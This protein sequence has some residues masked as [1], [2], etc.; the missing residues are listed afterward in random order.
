MTAA[1]TLAAAWSTAALDAYLKWYHRHEV[2]LDAA[3]PD[4]PV[5]FVS[6][7][8][9]GGIV[10]LNVL[11]TARIRDVAQIA[12]PTIALVHQLA[13]TMGVGPLVEALGGRPASKEAADAA[14]AAG[15]NVLVFPGGDLDAGKSWRDRNTIRFDKRCGFARLAIDHG[16][17]IVPIVTAGAGESALVLSDGRRLARALRLPELL[18]VKALPISLSI[19]WGLSVGVA[20]MLPYTAV[21]AKLASAVLPAVTPEPGE[22]PEDLADRVQRAMQLRMDELVADRIPVLG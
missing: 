17:P 16:V 10:D 19:P 4:E 1:S 14:F 3:V 8:G 6:N 9:F 2:H 15:N 20:G 7:H 12:R 13:W 22:S 21:P 11:A 5:L 18:R